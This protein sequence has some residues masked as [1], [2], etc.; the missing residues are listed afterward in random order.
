[1]IPRLSKGLAT[2]LVVLV[3]VVTM[4]GCATNYQSAGF[5]GGY[6]ETRL[7]ENVFSVNFRGNGY[8]R[9]QRAHDF[10]LLRSAELSLMNGY[11]YFVITQSNS[12]IST[13][14]YTTPTQ[15]TTT[16]QVRIYSSSAYGSAR[17]TTTGGQT[18]NVSKPRVSLVIICFEEKPD[19]DATVFNAEFLSKSIKEKYG[20]E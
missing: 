19:I 13:S 8:T 2:M 5:T 7:D 1:M 4:T 3:S 6:E 11:K 20:I 9:R 16:G 18:Y 14:T 17:T 10:A 12:Y 15:S